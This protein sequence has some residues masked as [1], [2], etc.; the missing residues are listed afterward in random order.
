[1]ICKAVNTASGFQ[2]SILIFQPRQP[3]PPNTYILEQSFGPRVFSLLPLVLFFAYLYLSILTL[4]GVITQ[5]NVRYQSLEIVSKHHWYNSHRYVRQLHVL[6]TPLHFHKN[7]FHFHHL[8]D[9][10][11]G[12]SLEAS[13]VG[14]V[15]LRNLIVVFLELGDQLSG[16]QL[17]VTSSCLNDLGLLLECEVLPGEVW[18][19]VFLEEGK[20]LVV[21]DG[22]WVGEVV[23]SGVLV[24]S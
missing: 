10:S 21:G 20:D 4:I 14:F 7:K 13:L 17:A 22:S 11:L 15:D 18:A 23:D 24:L 2:G 9:P 16:V 19:D 3:T 1:M 5:L 8:F 12:H 6:Q